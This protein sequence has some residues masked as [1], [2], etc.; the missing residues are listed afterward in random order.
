MWTSAFKNGC[1]GGEASF[2][3]PYDVFNLMLKSQARI[4]IRKGF[5][6]LKNLDHLQTKGTLA[7]V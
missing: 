2:C 6:K 7:K 1:F 3:F 4:N 5:L